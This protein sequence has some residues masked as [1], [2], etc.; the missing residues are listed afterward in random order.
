MAE[1]S[2]TQCLEAGFSALKEKNYPQAIAFLEQVIQAPDSQT[3]PALPECIKAQMG[4]V[5]AYSQMGDPERAIGLAQRLLQQDNPKVQQWAER[6]LMELEPPSAAPLSKLSNPIFPDQKSQDAGF[7]P[8]DKPPTA[9]GETRRRIPFSA[10]E[11]PEELPSQLSQPSP[12]SSRGISESLAPIDA[13]QALVDPPMATALPPTSAQESKTPWHSGDWGEA[14]HRER[15]T[16]W[17]TLPP[18]SQ[19]PLTLAQISVPIA[20][21]VIPLLL[22]TTQYV[23]DVLRVSFATRILRWSQT[24]PSWEFP[25]WWIL[26]SLVICYFASPWFLDWILR[27]FYGLKQLSTGTLAQY[28]PESHRLLQRSCQQQKMPIPTLGILQISFPLVMSYGFSAK[29]ARIV[30]SQGCLDRLEDAE[31]AT[32]YAAEMGHIV[33]KTFAPL[34]WVTTVIQIPHLMYWQAANLGDRLLRQAD[35]VTG[36]KAWLGGLTRIPAY[37]LGIISA[38]AYSLF[39]VFRWAGLKLSRDRIAYSDRIACNLTGNPNGLA[40]ALV[41]LAMGTAEAVSQQGAVDPILEGFE[42]LQPLS[43]R[44]TLSLGS[45]L[46]H[47]SPTQLFAWETSHPLRS[48]L[49][50]NQPS[51]LLADRLST[52]M[53][54]AQTWNLQPEFTLP[55]LLQ[56]RSTVTPQTRT[57]GHRP[58]SLFRVAAPFW[59][60][61]GG[62]LLAGLAWVLGWLAFQTGQY[63]LTWLGSDYG[64][65]MGLPLLGFG[66]GTIWRF[67]QFFPEIPLSLLRSGQP[68]QQGQRE[69]ENL[70]ELA[71]FLQNPSLDPLQPYRIKLEGQLLGRRGISNWLG[72]DLWL[73]TALGILR[74]HYMSQLGPIGNWL[75]YQHRPSDQIGQSVTVVGWLRRGATPW[76]DMELLRSPIGRN[77]GGHPVWSTIIAILAIVAGLYFLL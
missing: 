74:L 60:G 1:T 27:Q 18:R 3:Q 35:K 42:L 37:A 58:A 38:L 76:L 72:Q 23:L 30:V 54:Y 21:I 20:L 75:R 39:W 25:A 77:Y 51:T 15:S 7:V 11:T 14:T 6:Q 52:L 43:Y 47:F 28:S 26:P 69:D 33:H 5:T 36:Q 9:P 48:W 67:N 56:S 70:S 57:S 31:I 50:L 13:E 41:K 10:G 55:N 12:P 46:Q 8:L 71:E 64:L 49:S 32:L 2:I 29:N 16:K 40:R 66:L 53:T 63:R 59:C 45:A 24:L 4:L 44:S 17:S 62:Y 65:F 61:L 34:S 73:Q 19:L 68:S 22:F